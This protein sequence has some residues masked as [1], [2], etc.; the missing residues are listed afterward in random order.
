[1]SSILRFVREKGA[2]DQSPITARIMTFEPLATFRQ[3]ISDFTAAI[4]V[5]DGYKTPASVGVNLNEF[6]L[7]S[8]VIKDRWTQELRN[9]ARRTGLPTIWLT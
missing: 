2:A 7:N 6:G 4:R 5:G 3:A 8:R 1:M 9:P